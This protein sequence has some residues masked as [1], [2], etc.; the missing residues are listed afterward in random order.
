MPATY[1]STDTSLKKLLHDLL[2]SQHGR[3]TAFQQQYYENVL[4]TKRALNE[5]CDSLFD[6]LEYLCPRTPHKDKDGNFERAASS[7]EENI[8]Q[9]LRSPDVKE[10][11]A[12]P[13][14]DEIEQK[15]FLEL[16]HLT[17]KLKP[18]KNIS[19]AFIRAIMHLC[20]VQMLSLD[21]IRRFFYL[22]E[23]ILVRQ[24][25]IDCSSCI[26]LIFNAIKQTQHMS[27]KH[28]PKNAPVSDISI[29]EE[30]FAH[31][32][33]AS[34][35]AQIVAKQNPLLAS[36]R[37]KSKNYAANRKAAQTELT[38]YS[39]NACPL[40]GHSNSKVTKK[41]TSNLN[42]NLKNASDLLTAK[43]AAKNGDNG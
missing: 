29:L 30:Q 4:D 24:A 35:V 38:N 42:S 5:Q 37:I 8:L 28:L 22:F 26:A 3:Q 12:S 31:V 15:L 13:T 25:P 17:Y 1:E 7:L 36:G 14:F 27:A 10:A 33:S 2:A 16:K 19:P 11:V 40:C 41:P 18:L 9:F 21:L 34:D 32:R 43:L 6:Q 20:H 39:K 23:T